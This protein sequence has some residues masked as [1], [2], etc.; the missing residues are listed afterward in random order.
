MNE[1]DQLG[2][3]D[4]IMSDAVDAMDSALG[5]VAPPELGPPRRASRRQWTPLLIAAGLLLVAL[6]AATSLWTT[7]E[8]G[9]IAG[10]GEEPAEVNA[11]GEIIVTLADPEDAGFT[12]RAASSGFRSDDDRALQTT[13]QVPEKGA[14]PWERAVSVATTPYATDVLQGRVVDVGGPDAVIRTRDAALVWR[15]GDQVHSISSERLDS[16]ELVA[17]AAEAVGAGWSGSGPLPG[18][19]IAARG[20]PLDFTP[21]FEPTMLAPEVSAISYGHTDDLDFVI[22]SQPGSYGLW[23]ALLVNALDVRSLQLGDKFNAVAATYDVGGS[24]P[25]RVISWLEGDGTIVR[26]ATLGDVNALAE[27]LEGHLVNVGSEG[28]DAIETGYPIDGDATFGLDVAPPTDMSIDFTDLD[29]PWSPPPGGRVLAEVTSRAGDTTSRSAVIQ[30]GAGDRY[31]QAV[32]VRPG[33]GAG[34]N[35]PVDDATRPVFPISSGLNVDVGRTDG[36]T[37]NTRIVTG[38][39]PQGWTVTEIRD[40]QTG[41]ALPVLDEQRSPVDGANT[42]LVL[43]VVGTDQVDGALLEVVVAAADGTLE[44]HWL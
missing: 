12:L 38:V 42:I 44:R 11:G 26:I 21:L 8:Q 13:V 7:D 18:R 39:I 10:E 1:T 34:T 24:T 6:V 19:L 17:V 37:S 14:S 3:L 22:A 16:D 20:T 23:Q 29:A 27:F 30:D 2:K 31:V 41:V 4:E 5:D 43:A 40:Q 9:T 36:V 32:L 28:F 33:N 25:V 15:D 35:V